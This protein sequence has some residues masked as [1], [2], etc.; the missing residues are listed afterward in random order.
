MPRFLVKN[1]SKT[2][3]T[4]QVKR[5]VASL[6]WLAWPR[7]R[8][9]TIIE[10]LAATAVFVLMI[11]LLM[12]AVSQINQ[13]WRTSDGQKTRRESARAL[14][15]LMT[16]DLQGALISPERAGV[17]TTNFVLNADGGP[18]QDDSLFWRTSSPADRSKSDLATVGYFVNPSS[19]S[20][21]RYYTNTVTGVTLDGAASASTS[22]NPT[23]ANDFQGLVADGIFGMFVTLYG[24]NGQ[25]L[26]VPLLASAKPASVEVA[27]VV[28]D[29]QSVEKN[30]SYVP[31][32]TTKSEAL[33]SGLQWFRTRVEIPAGQ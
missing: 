15:D 32:R 3:F 21:C 26:P 10:L 20:L 25:A 16:R 2:P 22:I 19:K 29:K 11:T 33:P 24:T 4:G 1:A 27:L 7:R 31:E 6:G 28:G 13:A 14:L 23:Q 17:V 9:F 8:A 30:A 12:S 18:A 5:P